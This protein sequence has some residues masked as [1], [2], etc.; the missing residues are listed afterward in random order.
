MV[1]S[2]PIDSCYG[3][4][5]QKLVDFV[6]SLTTRISQLG[7]ATLRLENGTGYDVGA[8]FGDAASC[9]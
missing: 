4:L 3:Q 8:G 2:E 6:R 1:F 5:R 9:L 7:P